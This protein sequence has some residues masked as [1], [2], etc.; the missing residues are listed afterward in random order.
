[1]KWRRDRAVA[2]GREV[3][4]VLEMP[5][6][7]RPPPPPLCHDN[8][9]LTHQNSTPSYKSWIHHCVVNKKRKSNSRVSYN[10]ISNRVT[11]NVTNFLTQCT[12][13]V[14]AETQLMETSITR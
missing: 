6:I 13:H 1:M 8:Y 4:D 7:Y 10:T 11:L 12:A 9:S 5:L 3:I 14:N 2:D